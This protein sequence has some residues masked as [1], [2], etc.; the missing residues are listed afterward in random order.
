MGFIAV[1]WSS[2]NELLFFFILFYYSFLPILIQFLIMPSIPKT[3][4]ETVEAEHDLGNWS[5]LLEQHWILFVFAF[6]VCVF[7]LIFG[8]CCW[9]K[10]N[11]TGHSTNIF[12][13]NDNYTTLS[14]IRIDDQPDVGAV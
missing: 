3:I 11:L 14:N 4:A 2:I 12:C 7:Y 8:V 5:S 9:M 1:R 10:E 13:N 6:G